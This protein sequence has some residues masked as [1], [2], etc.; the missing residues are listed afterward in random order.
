MRTIQKRASP[1]GPLEVL[2]DMFLAL[3]TF[4]LLFRHHELVENLTGVFGVS[5]LVLSGLCYLD[6]GVAWMIYFW[7][8]P[9]H[10]GTRETDYV[11]VYF[12]YSLVPILMGI[13]DL[14]SVL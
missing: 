8:I 10:N 5:G 7:H 14:Y 2:R 13:G 3:L 6:V 1:N 11:P 12:I 9:K 4:A